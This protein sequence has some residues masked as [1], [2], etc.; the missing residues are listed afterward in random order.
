[1][2][3]RRFLYFLTFVFV[4]I[5]LLTVYMQYNSNKNLKGLIVAE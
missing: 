2:R 5:I 4:A 1:M 3:F